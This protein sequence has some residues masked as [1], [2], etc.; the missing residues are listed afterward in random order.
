MDADRFDSFSDE[1]LRLIAALV[2]G[3]LLNNALLIARLLNQNVPPEASASFARPL[4]ADYH[5]S[6]PIQ[7]LK[8]D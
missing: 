4:T 7:Q 2:A 6:A 5:S 1:E 3:A 8:R